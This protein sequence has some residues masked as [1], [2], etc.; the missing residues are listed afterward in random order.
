MPLIPAGTPAIRNAPDLSLTSAMLTTTTRSRP[1]RSPT[2]RRFTD[3]RGLIEHSRRI[4]TWGLKTP[5]CGSALLYQRQ[6]RPRFPRHFY[7]CDRC[8]RRYAAWEAEW[9]P[10]EV[11]RGVPDPRRLRGTA[12]H[13]RKSRGRS[14]TPTQPDAPRTAS[15]GSATGDLA[16]TPRGNARLPLIDRSQ[17]RSCA[18][19]SRRPD[20]SLPWERPRSLSHALTN[21]YLSIECFLKYLYCLVREQEVSVTLYASPMTVELTE[22][23]A[24]KTRFRDH[25][26]QK[27]TKLLS[28][29][30][31][32]PNFDEYRVNDIAD[33][34]SSSSSWRDNR[35]ATHVGFSGTSARGTPRGKTGVLNASERSHRD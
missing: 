33:G 24:A 29:N 15:E 3:R 32:L 31:D 18:R 12:T 1:S 28:A 35:P 17:R 23:L 6:E 26:L 22:S 21:L 19:S 9:M 20:K 4:S 2:C 5:C 11:W 16:V 25:D 8:G 13:A 30:T 7:W 10:G 14:L 27:I 34:F